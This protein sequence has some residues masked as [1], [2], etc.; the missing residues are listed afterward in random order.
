MSASPAATPVTSPLLTSAI[1]RLDEA[2]GTDSSAVLKVTSLVVPSENTAMAEKRVLAPTS[3]AVPTIATDTSVR[4]PAVVG[5]VAGEL[6]PPLQAVSVPTIPNVRDG[7]NNA[8][9]EALYT[10]LPRTATLPNLTG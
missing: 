7:P 3:G 8:R 1:A 2:H 9:T 6:E 5:A 4:G 10:V